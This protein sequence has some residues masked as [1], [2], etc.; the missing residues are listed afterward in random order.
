MSR[1]VAPICIPDPDTVWS[2]DNTTCLVSGWGKTK[3]ES[4]QA[5]AVM[6]ETHLFCQHT[7][8]STATASGPPPCPWCPTASVPGCTPPHPRWPM[9]Q[10]DLSPDPCMS[11]LSWP[12]CSVPGTLMAVWTPARETVA[13]RWSANTKVTPG[14][15]GPGET[16]LLGYLTGALTDLTRDLLET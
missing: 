9:S 16:T 4:T 11:S 14:T 13:A 8:V 7:T 5:A 2:P 3:S 12:A 10:Y 15:F 6:K 1:T